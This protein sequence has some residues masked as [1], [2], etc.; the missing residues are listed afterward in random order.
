MPD[1]RAMMQ[2]I[3]KMKGGKQAVRTA[4]MNKIKAEGARN[5]KVGIKQVAREIP[6]VLKR[7]AVKHLSQNTITSAKKATASIKYKK[8]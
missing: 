4:R 3:M 8:K 7:A 6:G 1:S 5:S 2:K